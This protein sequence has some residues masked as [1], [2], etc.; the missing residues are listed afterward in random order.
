MGCG[1]TFNCNHP[2]VQRLVLDSLRH[3]VEE[4]HVDGFRFDLTSSM[5]R[6]QNGGAVQA[7]F[8]LPVYP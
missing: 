3:W 6:D 5:C 4:Y 8:I 7:E 1:N 2:R